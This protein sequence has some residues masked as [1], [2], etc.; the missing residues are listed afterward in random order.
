MLLQTCALSKSAEIN[1]GAARCFKFEQ[2]CASLGENSGKMASEFLTTLPTYCF[3]C[4]VIPHVI[5]RKKI[6]HAFLETPHLKVT[7]HY[8]VTL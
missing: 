7:P 3:L 8:V 5:V 6:F 1:W 4:T 2:G